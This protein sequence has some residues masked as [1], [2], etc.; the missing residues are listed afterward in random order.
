[1]KKLSSFGQVPVR[2][3]V[4]VNITMPGRRIPKRNCKTVEVESP[5]CKNYPET[6][7]EEKT[8]DKCEMEKKEQCVTFEMPSFS[9]VSFSICLKDPNGR[10]FT[11]RSSNSDQSKLIFG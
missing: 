11:F 10:V 4:P 7:E 3:P 8:V 5:V 1:M 2:V 6:V 9:I